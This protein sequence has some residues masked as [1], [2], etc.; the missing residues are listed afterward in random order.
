MFLREKFRDHLCE[1]FKTRTII[2]DVQSEKETA[3]NKGLLQIERI[4][5]ERGRT[6]HYSS[7]LETQYNSAEQER[8]TTR[9]VKVAK[10]MLG[11]R[12]S[13][14]PRNLL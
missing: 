10:H 2:Y 11:A 14:V 12:E 8:E 6:S 9:W 7:L 5:R 13:K 4:L 3:Y 1:T